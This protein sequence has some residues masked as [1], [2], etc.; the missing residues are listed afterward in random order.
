MNVCYPAGKGKNDPEGGLDVNKVA[1]RE[2]AW[3][4]GDAVSSSVPEIMATS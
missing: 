3:G 4:R 1:Q 2:Q